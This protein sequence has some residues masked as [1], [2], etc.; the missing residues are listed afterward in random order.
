MG[1]FCAGV[2]L[3]GNGVVYRICFVPR[4]P[5]VHSVLCRAA[6]LPPGATSEAA[7]VAAI[8]ARAV[9]RSAA[10]CAKAAAGTGACFRR[11]ALNLAPGHSSSSSSSSA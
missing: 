5:R 8:A 1:F 4:P 3:G 2:A 7:A 6:A 10:S 9:A 11:L